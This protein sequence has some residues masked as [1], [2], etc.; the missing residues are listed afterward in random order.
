MRK[1][2]WMNP[3]LEALVEKVGDGNF[4]RRL[5]DVAERY[6][7]IMR[8]TPAPELFPEE[9]LILSEVIGGSKLT[10]T[11]IRRMDEWVLDCST[12]TAAEREALSA[13]A[14]GWSAAERIAVV[15]LLG[16]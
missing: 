4:S 5:G 9:K 14:A 3:P 15:E 12:G 1:N 10:P 16:V 7:L 6:D 2:I 13:K 11:L 8:L